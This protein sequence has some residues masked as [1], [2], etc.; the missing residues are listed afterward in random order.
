MAACIENVSNQALEAGFIPIPY[1]FTH[2]DK[3]LE[4][5]VEVRQVVLPLLILGD[6]F[7]LSLQEF[8]PLLLQSLPLGPL[9]VNPR[10]H[11]L[12]LVGPRVLRMLDKEFLGGDEG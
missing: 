5:L 9:V 12:V 7:S 11:Q 6:K 8:L 4:V 3:P 1:G 10:Y 2:V